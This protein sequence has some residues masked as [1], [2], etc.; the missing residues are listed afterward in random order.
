MDD[1]G[2]EPLGIEPIG[3]SLGIE[4]LGIEPL[5]PVK[6]APVRARKNENYSNE[7]R[8]K[9]FQEGPGMAARGADLAGGVLETLT[10]GLVK[11]VGG[12]A[13]AGLGGAFGAAMPGMTAQEGMQKAGELFSEYTPYLNPETK[14]G[15]KFE[16]KVGNLI[17]SF[18]GY[19]ADPDEIKQLISAIPFA[20][21]Q[22]SEDQALQAVVSSLGQSIPELA[23]VL[24]IPTG[25]RTF[26]GKGTI[27]PADEVKA[28]NIDAI[29][30]QKKAKAVADL[31]IEPIESPVTAAMQPMERMAAELA[32]GAERTIREPVEPSPMTSM[33]EDLTRPTSTAT[34]AADETM[35][36]R[37]AALDQEMKQRVTLEQN[38]RLRAEQEAAPV[39]SE[40]MKAHA[41]EVS[42]AQKAAQ[43]AEAAVQAA[44]QAKRTEAEGTAQHAEAVRRQEEAQHALEL[45]QTELELAVKK[46]ASLDFGAAERARQ[47]TAPVFNK[48]QGG[49]VSE[50][51]VHILRTATGYV[52]KVGDK[53]VGKL[54]SNMT[55]EQNRMLQ[56]RGMGE[57]ASVDIVRVDS[58][59]KGK[60]VGRALYDAWTKDHGGN[61]APSGKTTADAWAYWKRNQPEKVEQFIKAEAERASVNPSNLRNITDDTVRRQVAEKMDQMTVDEASKMYE[62]GTPIGQYKK[63]GGYIQMPWKKKAEVEQLKRLPGIG[64]GMQQFQPEPLRGEQ[65]IDKYK[66]AADVD[67]NFVQ[68]FINNFTKSGDYQAEKTGN[69]IVKVVQEELKGAVNRSQ[70]AQRQIVHD[71]YAR[72]A[73]KLSE[74]EMT[75]AW[76]GLEKQRIAGHRLTADELEAAGF[77]KNEREFMLNHN[78]VMDDMLGRLNEGLVAAGHKPVSAEAAHTASKAVGNFR[79]IM[80]KTVEGEKVVAGVLGADTKIGLARDVKRFQEH[81]PDTEGGPVSSHMG[82]GRASNVDPMLDALNFLSAGD[83]TVAEFMDRVKQMTDEQAIAY[84]GTKTHTMAKKGVPGM[85]GNRP[86]ESDFQNAKHGIEAQVSY[87]NRVI[88]MAELAKAKERLDPILAAPEL[89]M[90]AAKSWARDKL[91]TAFGRNPTELGNALDS[92]MR[93]VA[94][95][96]GVGTNVWNKIGGG[97]RQATNTL[98][99]SMNPRFLIGNALDPIKGTPGMTQYLKSVGVSKAGGTGLYYNY[100]ALIDVAKDSMGMKLDPVIEGAIKFAEDNHVYASDLYESSNSIR[101]DT[102]YYAKAVLQG[103]AGKVEQL[104][105]QNVFLGFTHL[106]NETSSLTPKTGLYDA[107]LRATDM[108]MGT[109]TGLDSPLATQALGAAG[110]GPYNLL[111]YKANTLSRLSMFARDMKATSP[112]T[113]KPM[114]TEMLSQ[115]AFGGLRGTILYAEA[116]YVVRKLSEMLG[117]PTSLTKI[118]LDSGNKVA[119]HIPL[120]GDVT[121]GNLASGGLSS[122]TGIDFTNSMGV[123][124]VLGDLSQPLNLLMPGSSKLVDVAKTGAELAGDPHEFNAKKAIVN[125]LPGGSLLERPFFSQGLGTEREMGINKNTG[126]AGAVRTPSDKVAKSMGMT[127]LAESN[128]RTLKYEND[129][130][131]KWYA[132]KQKQAVER[133]GKQF[134]MSGTI[135]KRYVDQFVKAQGNPENLNKAIE[136]FALEQNIPASKMEQLKIAAQ[137]TITSAQKMKRRF[138]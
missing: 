98:L 16:E 69:P 81:F 93:A 122:L 57:P 74:E 67:Q 95:S 116:D 30:E 133:M 71:G 125:M 124:P 119:A 108:V 82:G 15:K 137:N 132:D 89:D 107:A 12:A 88:E 64:R 130:I 49:G 121:V 60:G 76:M 72:L 65:F 129:T 91:D 7:G 22:L 19:A 42:A 5:E 103:P 68:K 17:E 1:L 40:A 37:Q 50:D 138:H 35:A 75:N 52:A 23:G 8:D 117:E 123:G 18:K 47:E 61:V 48:R 56:E 66:T 54:D 46:Q 114:A 59:V 38:A 94:K 9:P 128:E 86:W 6:Q 62:P 136:T 106:L 105:R 120:L 36:L 134:F 115:V 44:E 77:T 85:P 109:Y 34:R 100:K 11:G 55:P 2:I 99:L 10:T 45:R 101:K 96:T 41:E 87:I 31:G 135:D 90:P 58:D 127:G 21:K 113:W 51:V 126:Q 79:Q 14:A 63:Q 112:S 43:D 131:D 118:L 3:D 102:G 13:A 29:L 73:R 92:V 97:I 80:Y 24:T 83:S 84:R 111:S 4:P 33:A 25:P 78:A 26:R 53:I 27:K 32:P 39:T 28:T 110:R 20:G 104:S 70:A